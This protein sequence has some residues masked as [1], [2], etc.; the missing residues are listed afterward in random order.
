M[1]KFTRQTVNLPQLIQMITDRLSEKQSLTVAIDGRCGG[2]K[3]TLAQAL[4]AHFS[5]T[6][7]HAD[8]F[9]LR[10]EQ[11]MPERFAEPGGNMDRERLIAEVL[12]PL[13]IGLPF[14]YRPFDCSTLSLAEPISVDP[15]PLTIVEGSYSCHP[16][17]WDCYDL[18][19]FVDVDSEEQLRRITKRNGAAMAKVFAERWIPLEERYFK[20]FSI[21]EKCEI[22]FGLSPYNA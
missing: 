10:P 11:R 1:T 15:A 18:H 19:I 22:V 6:L 4:Q 7:I 3:T 14:S 16:D 13:K 20:A 21:C 9:F 17:L 5:A 2:G 12:L 8:D